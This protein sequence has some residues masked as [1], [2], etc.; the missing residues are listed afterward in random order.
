MHSLGREAIADKMMVRRRIN[1]EAEILWRAEFLN[2]YTNEYHL[3][4]LVL[5]ISGGVDSA[6]AGK[7]CK[8]ATKLDEF[9]DRWFYALRLPYGNQADSEDADKVIRFLDPHRTITIDIK[10]SVDALEKQ[11]NFDHFK[12]EHRDFARGNL[13][14]RARMAAHYYV[15]N[16]CKGVVVGTDHSA[17]GVMGFFTK[18]G[19]G[20]AD[21]CPL[22]G[23]SKRQV[24]ELGSA[25]GVPQEIVEK[26]ATADLEDL[27]PGIPDEEVLGVSYED[28]DNLLEGLPVTEEARKTIEDA[29]NRTE[30]KRRT[31]IT[32]YDK[33]W[34]RGSPFE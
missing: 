23:L 19:D 16:L 13:K 12:E 21:V 22:F 27:R 9:S 2:D 25:F 17:E 32:P 31:P 26:T 24:R 34:R 18:F 8:I 20:G 6:V 11:F 28:I 7:L 5:G 15:A 14:A 3:K 4:C 33:W 1:L 29:Y 30:H 10:P